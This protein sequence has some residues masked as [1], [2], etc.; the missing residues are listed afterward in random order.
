M[1]THSH[2]TPKD[3]LAH[4]YSH[5]TELINCT[6]HEELFQLSRGCNTKGV[7]QYVGPAILDNDCLVSQCVS[8]ISLALKS[9]PSI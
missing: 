9:V 1:Y 5:S 6:Q 2:N 3:R 8:K 4:S 7:P